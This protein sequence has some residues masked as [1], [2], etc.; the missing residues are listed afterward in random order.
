MFEWIK[1]NWEHVLAV[2]GA[3]YTLALVIVK[4]TPTKKDDEAL[5]KVSVLVRALAFVFGL[6]IP[7][8]KEPPPEVKRRVG[9]ARTDAVVIVLL[10][11]LA[12][13]AGCASAGDKYQAS[14]MAFVSVVNTATELNKAGKLEPGDVA[15]IDAAIDEGHAVLNAWAEA[16][17]RGEDYPSGM[18][19]VE[20]VVGRIRAHLRRE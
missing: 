6:R 4:L 16:L 19:V 2:V 3:A 5:E 18:E 12:L 11:T 7:A 13:V 1:E 20:L 14:A 8:P 10:L 9:Q 15:A 17:K